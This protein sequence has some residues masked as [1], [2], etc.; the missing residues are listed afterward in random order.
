MPISNDMMMQISQLL[1]NS[2]GWSLKPAD[3]KRITTAIKALCANQ[4][5]NESD[6]FAQLLVNES[7]Q[8]QIVDELV[9]PETYFFRYSKSFDHLREQASQWLLENK[10]G[11]LRIASI[12]SATGEECY[13]I[14]MILHD[15]GIP[16]ERFSVDAID[17]SALLIERAKQGI[18]SRHCLRRHPLVE[19]SKYFDEV[20]GGLQVK[21]EIR[22]RVNF[23]QGN[24]KAL[25][26]AFFQTKYPIVFCR[27][28]LIYL[29][30]DVRMMLFRQLKSMLTHDGELFAGPAEVSFFLQQ[31]MQ[32]VD[33]TQV[34][35][36]QFLSPG[37]TTTRPN[38]T[39]ALT[40]LVK[41]GVAA[42]PAQPRPF[43]N[44]N[45]RKSLKVGDQT[46]NKARVPDVAESV[47]KS[48]D[49][50][51][52]EVRQLADS[53]DLTAAYRMNELLLKKNKSVPAFLLQGEILLA[54]ERLSESIQAMKKVLYLEPDNEDALSHLVLMCKRKGH[55]ADATRY[56]QSLNGCR[57]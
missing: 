24:V 40:R 20:S 55:L 6:F 10:T 41:T 22:D 7:L 43:T 9:I 18:Y 53:G 30:N 47:E 35:S 48:N 32:P 45:K 11:M 52:I 54:M 3:H 5:F 23:M 17:V 49:A 13:S 51:L 50:V 42:K 36:L 15:A 57:G 27:N 25:P 33:K 28:L 56:Q 31:G 38:K 29:T 34:F 8:Q 19:Q 21:V 16:L 2:C 39:K 46:S 1:G 26:A 12:P 37:L 44:E 4:A 14:A